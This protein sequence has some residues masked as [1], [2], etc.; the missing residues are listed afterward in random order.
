MDGRAVEQGA[1]SLPSSVA[2]R[3]RYGVCLRSRTARGA[4]RAWLCCEYCGG[5]IEGT[6]PSLALS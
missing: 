6:K 5:L 1:P 3:Q 2:G 4:R